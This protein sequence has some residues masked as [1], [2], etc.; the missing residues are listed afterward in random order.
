MLTTKVDMR[1][2]SLFLSGLPYD[3]KYPVHDDPYNK[4]FLN[5]FQEKA[6]GNRTC[7]EI[8]IGPLYCSCLVLKE[9]DKYYYDNDSKDDLSRLLRE[10]AKETIVAINAEV[11][12]PVTVMGNIICKKL[13]FKSIKKAFGLQLSSV[14]EEFQIQFEVNESENALFEVYALA[15]SSNRASELRNPGG[16]GASIPFVYLDYKVKIKNI[17]ISRKDAYAGPCENL[18]R[19]NNI[20]SEYCIC[21]DFDMIRSKYPKLFHN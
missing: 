17:G 13:T 9:I 5:M 1:A 12:T 21:Q 16:Q 7:A 19:A 18:S 20:N 10:V 2:T 6:I 14:M 4:P 8:G 15:G 11:F 3:I